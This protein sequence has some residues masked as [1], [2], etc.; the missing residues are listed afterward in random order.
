[1]ES[2]LSSSPSKR[3]GLFLSQAQNLKIVVPERSF[4]KI[5][6]QPLSLLMQQPNVLIV[7]VRDDDYIGGHIKGSIHYPFS[8]FEE[9]VQKINQYLKDNDKDTIVFYCMYSEQRA[10]QCVSTFCD[11][12]DQQRL[13]ELKIYVLSGGL[14]AFLKKY[15]NSELLEDYNRDYFIENVDGMLLHKTDAKFLENTLGVNSMNQQ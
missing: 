12:L 15:P 7:D 14:N 2:T 1:M 10:P 11:S 3:K 4:K 9:S 8:S 5:D 6:P 13:E